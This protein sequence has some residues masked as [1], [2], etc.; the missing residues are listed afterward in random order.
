M[1]CGADILTEFEQNEENLTE[2][3][4]RMEQHLIR[5]RDYKIIVEQMK[6]ETKEYKADRKN[7]SYPPRVKLMLGLVAKYVCGSLY[8]DFWLIDHE[9]FKT[10]R[11]K[12][13]VARAD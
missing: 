12:K 10:F 3:K 13:K 11:V 6:T 4:H 8:G 5:Q 9:I 1:T 2:I 7:G